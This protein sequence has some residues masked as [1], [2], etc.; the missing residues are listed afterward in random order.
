MWAVQT[1]WSQA[2]LWSNRVRHRKQQTQSVLGFTSNLNQPHRLGF[3]ARR[4][5]KLPTDKKKFQYTVLAVDRAMEL[6]LLLEGN[7]RDMGVT[8]L[9]KALGVQKS[10]VH[11]L[12]Q[13]LLARDVVRQTDSGRYTLGFRLMRLGKSAAER[14]AR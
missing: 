1:L 4:C 10:T 13:T 8:E 9:S 12:L 6:L 5:V 3:A 2:A 11:N 14:K 7:P